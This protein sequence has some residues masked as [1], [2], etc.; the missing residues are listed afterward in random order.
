MWGCGAR[1]PAALPEHCIKKGT[2]TSA[3]K[4]L[5]EDG[6]GEE[7]S[8]WGG[9]GEIQR[10]SVLKRMWDKRR[11]GIRLISEEYLSNSQMAFVF[12]ISL[13]LY[14]LSLPLIILDSCANA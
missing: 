5:G 8:A 14:L 10:R 1:E 7:F 3:P 11:K 4:T 2:R 9:V 13:Y 12:T 6:G